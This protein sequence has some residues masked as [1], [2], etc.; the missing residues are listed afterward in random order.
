[1]YGK[2]R[3]DTLHRVVHD[4][5]TNSGCAHNSLARPF[6]ARVWEVAHRL[7]TDPQPFLL[8]TPTWGTGLLEPGELVDRLDAYRRA[9][10]RVAAVDFGQALL[11]VRRD[12]RPAALAAAERAAALGTE[13][14]SGSRAG[15]SPSGPPLPSPGGRRTPGS[16][17]NS[18]RCP[19][20]GR[21]SSPPPCGCW[22]V[23]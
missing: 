23:R 8:A 11:R 13:E 4:G 14:G 9:G 22:G 19:T 16:W 15:C 2:V 5:L 6:E 7:R 20:S 17:W 12:N 3:T 21:R 10:A 1:M 18:V